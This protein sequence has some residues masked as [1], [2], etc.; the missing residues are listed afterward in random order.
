MAEIFL[1]N[2]Y[3]ALL[4]PL[5]I[6]LII[7]IG[8][9]FSVYVNKAVIY[10]LTLIS[11]LFG[12]ILC[13]GALWKL[14]SD[15]ILETGFPF[16]KIDDFIINCGLFIDRTALIFGLVLFLIS[17]FVQ[18]FSI[19]YMKEE[20]KTYRFYALMNLFN[21]SMAGLFFSPNLFQTYLFW[22]IAGIVSYLLIGFE[23][24]KKEKSIASRKVFIINRIGDTALIGAI[25]LSTYFI[26]SYAPNKALTTKSFVDMNII[27][28]V[29]Y[30]DFTVSGSVATVSPSAWKYC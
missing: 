15:K 28:T 16:L 30:F 25:M 19:S 29:M 24:F 21:F 13:G 18:M 3:L 26:Y 20:K 6:F 12:V 27:S 14:P 2:I 9:F 4:L 17:F 22:E 11:S 5:W 23:Y 10:A 8:R 1:D 7:M